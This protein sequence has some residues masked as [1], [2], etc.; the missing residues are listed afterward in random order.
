MVLFKVTFNCKINWA[1]VFYGCAYFYPAID[2]RECTCTPT[3]HTE[4]CT[5]DVNVRVPLDPGLKSFLP[6]PPVFPCSSCTSGRAR[7]ITCHGAFVY[8]REPGTEARK[9]HCSVRRSR[10]ARGAFHPDQRRSPGTPSGVCLFVG[11]TEPRIQL[12][13]L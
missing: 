12:I 6:G 2:F 4:P 3:T 1:A 7:A 5:R 13:P 8:R 10:S 11:N 9:T